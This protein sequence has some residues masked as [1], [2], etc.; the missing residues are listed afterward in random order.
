M[1]STISKLRNGSRVRT[2]CSS[3]S[4][5]QATLM[6]KMKCGCLDLGFGFLE[7]HEM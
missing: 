3:W 4:Q 2:R 5:L 6:N 7:W 1:F